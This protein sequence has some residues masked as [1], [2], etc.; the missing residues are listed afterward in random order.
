VQLAIPLPTTPDTYD[1]PLTQKLL[2]GRREFSGTRVVE[3]VK[4]GKRVMG[5]IVKNRCYADKLTKLADDAM[6]SNPQTSCERIDVSRVVFVV[7]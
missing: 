7:P 4:N 2:I 6:H 3:T 5:A 1:Y